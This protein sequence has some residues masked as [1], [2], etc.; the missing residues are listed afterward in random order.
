MVRRETDFSRSHAPFLTDQF[1]GRWCVGGVRGNIQS[2]NGLYYDVIFLS[3]AGCQIFTSQPVFLA[4][5]ICKL[6]SIFRR[7]NKSTRDIVP[8]FRH[9]KNRSLSH[10]RSRLAA[11]L[12]EIQ[13]I[14]I[15]H[16]EHVTGRSLKLLDS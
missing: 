8:R 14:L 2:H 12:K 7:R 9:L 16:C 5:T 15:R 4:G 10:F 3:G 11:S 13:S 6:N 1:S